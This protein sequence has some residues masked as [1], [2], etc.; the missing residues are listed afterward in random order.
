MSAVVSLSEDTQHKLCPWA[1]GRLAFSK[2]NGA[3]NWW[4]R[5]IAPASASRP[6]DGWRR[7]K[8]VSFRNTKSGTCAAYNSRNKVLFQPG[9]RANV[10]FLKHAQRRHIRSGERRSHPMTPEQRPP[11]TLLSIKT[12]LYFL[13]GTHPSLVDVSKWTDRLSG[14]WSDA[15]NFVRH[16]ITCFQT[17]Y[18]T[19]IVLEMHTRSSYLNWTPQNQTTLLRVQTVSHYKTASDECQLIWT[20]WIQKETRVYRSPSAWWAKR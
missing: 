19:L 2:R 12:P 18:C 4:R 5:Q 17:I 15:I 11:A 3:P 1:T 8:P 6:K 20:T 7:F 14:S 13:L 9:V 16:S 10:L